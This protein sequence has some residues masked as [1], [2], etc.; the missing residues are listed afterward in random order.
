[1]KG[2]LRGSVVSGVALVA[3]GFAASPGQADV[4]IINQDNLGI[5]C[6]LPGGCGTVTVTSVGTTYTFDVD[7]TAASGLT[8]HTTTGGTGNPDTVAFNLAGA[9]AASGPVTF[10]SGPV[11]GMDGFGT[12]LFGVDCTNTTSGNACV[13]TG[14]SPANDFIFTVTAPAGE[15]LTPNAQGNFLALDVICSLAACTSPTGFAASSVPGPIVGAGLPG[16]V[17][18][19]G[20]LI[21]LAR[22]RRQRL[23]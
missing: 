10:D 21:A 15:H 6:P 5:A 20:G 8:L 14:V 19:C 22:R 23:A 2:W 4:F 13:P 9:T 17:A 12:F 11:G 1:M 16:L 7:L 18:A 3:L